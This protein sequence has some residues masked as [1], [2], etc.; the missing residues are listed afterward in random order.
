MKWILEVLFIGGIV[1]YVA[2][3]S[4]QQSC[5]CPQMPEN[6]FVVETKETEMCLDENRQTVITKVTRQGKVDHYTN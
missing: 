2:S 6:Y 5:N 4:K 1:W 3:P